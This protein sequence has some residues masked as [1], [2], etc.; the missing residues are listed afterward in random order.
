MN[1]SERY[2]H[3]FK[4]TKLTT[5]LKTYFIANIWFDVYHKISRI[6]QKHPNPT[7]PNTHDIHVLLFKVIILIK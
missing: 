3:T 7:L 1:S 5:F 2:K 4:Q 6:L